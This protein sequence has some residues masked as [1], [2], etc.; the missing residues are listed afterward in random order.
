MDD[1]F[2]GFFVSYLVPRWVFLIAGS[3]FFTTGIGVL[4]LMDWARIVTVLLASVLS[5][6]SGLLAIFV[7]FHVVAGSLNT[8]GVPME[9]VPI[10]IGGMFGILCVGLLAVHL[11]FV[12]FFTRPSVKVQF[13]HST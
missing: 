7:I 4:M 3:I 12:F 8:S 10:F 6:L 5:G 2:F 1:L 11:W 13:R 9:W